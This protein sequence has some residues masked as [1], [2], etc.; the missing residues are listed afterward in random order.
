MQNVTIMTLYFC[1]FCLTQT[2]EIVSELLVCSCELAVSCD[3]SSG[4]NTGIELD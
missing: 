2:N 1:K 3:L 4:Q